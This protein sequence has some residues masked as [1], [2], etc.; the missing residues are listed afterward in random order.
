MFDLQVWHKQ[1]GGTHAPVAYSALYDYNSNEPGQLAFRK[2][3]SLIVTGFSDRFTLIGHVQGQRGE[4]HFP[5]T[6][7]SA[8]LF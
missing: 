7:V 8:F 2:D 3:D 6:Y 5:K 4:G 1:T